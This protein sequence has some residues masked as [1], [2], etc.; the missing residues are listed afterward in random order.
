[1]SA[2]AYIDKYYVG[3]VALLAT[4]FLAF[5]AWFLYDGYVKYPREHEVAMAFEQFEKQGIS[6][7]KLVAEWNAHAQTSG[8]PTLDITD[9][10]SRP[11]KKHA[12]MDMLTQKGLGFALL[13]LGLL[14]GFSV[15]RLF[16]RWIAVDENGLTTSWGKKIAF[17]E[18]T[19]LNKERWKTKGIAVVH[20]K[21]AGAT[22]ESRLVL[23]DWKYNRPATKII[24][25]AVQAHLT[26]EQITG[27]AAVSTPPVPSTPVN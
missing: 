19:K 11:G 5:S 14:F 8:Y 21:N 27:D 25:E 17:D 20:Y 13:P 2:K 6:R 9:T 24:V 1:M 10:E 15:V 18:I 16:G 4:M 22:A 3:R 12:D 23:D 26:P 7:D